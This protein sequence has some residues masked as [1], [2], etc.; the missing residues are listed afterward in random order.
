MD[1]LLLVHTPMVG[2]SSEGLYRLAELLVSGPGSSLP[3]SLVHADETGTGHAL[4]K[5]RGGL[6][7]SRAW[8]I[9]IGNWRPTLV[10]ELLCHPHKAAR[11]KRSDAD[12]IAGACLQ[13]GVPKAIGPRRVRL[14]IAQP[15]GRRPDPDGV[16]KS[17]LDGL[18]QARM[19]IDDSAQHCTCV[20]PVFRKGPKETI[21]ELEDIP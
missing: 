15:G 19:L 10:N 21:V 8:T 17:L 16:W 7:M 6:G 11:L 1:I 20:P 13:T 12:L 18:V 4:P 3:G 9:Q 2:L 5:L 14:T